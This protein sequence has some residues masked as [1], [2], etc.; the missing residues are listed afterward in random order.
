MALL[1]LG[2]ALPRLTHANAALLS[3][4]YTAS[5]PGAGCDTGGALWTVTPGEP[6]STTC[7][8]AGLHVEIGRGPNIEGAV[9]F[10]PPNGFASQNY[11]ISVNIAL[12]S[13][14]DGCAGIF[15]RASAAGRYLTV[16]CGDGSVDIDKLGAGGSSLIYLKFVGRAPNYTIT[17]VSQGPRQSVYIGGVKVGTVADAS[18]SETEYIGL[19]IVSRSSEAESAVF[20]HFVFKPLPAS[21]RA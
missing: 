3:A 5:V 4:P 13:G 14:F 11:S 12:S 2:T 21:R 20:S 8:S 6:I 19:G 17:A 16:V 1:I 15:T 9:K 7:G 18:L 10:L